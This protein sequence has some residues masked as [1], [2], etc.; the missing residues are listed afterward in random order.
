MYTSCYAAPR[1]QKRKIVSLNTRYELIITPQNKR[2]WLSD[3][4]LIPEHGTEYTFAQQLNKVDFQFH[5]SLCM[6]S[7]I[8]DLQTSVLF[9]G[10]MSMTQFKPVGQPYS[11]G[12]DRMGQRV[13]GRHLT[14]FHPLIV[15]DA[16]SCLLV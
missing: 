11:G 5:F 2:T 8:I 3:T 13:W 4:S 10:F 9:K 7:Q 12:L 6:F 14:R 16:Q 15:L 1:C